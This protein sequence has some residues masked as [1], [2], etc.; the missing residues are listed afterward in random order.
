MG[1]FYKK[2][3]ANRPEIKTVTETEFEGRPMLALPTEFP[4][5]PIQMTLPK[6]RI[7]R[8]HW[9]SYIVPF[10]EKHKDWEDAEDKKAKKPVSKP[11]DPAPA[12]MPQP[13]QISP[14][15]L[16]EAVR[17]LTKGAVAAPA[18]APAAEP[19]T[20]VEPSVSDRVARLRARLGAK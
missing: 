12:A 14:E 17:L 7:I 5:F 18:E 1:R 4:R 20:E 15:L 6:W 3:Q 9:E 2:Q 19:A 13:Q 11:V 16:A 10:L 8:D